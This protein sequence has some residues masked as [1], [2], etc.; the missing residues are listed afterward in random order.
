MKHKLKNLLT[1]S[2]KNPE[3]MIVVSMKKVKTKNN[4]SN[5]STS[6]AFKSTNC[7][8]HTNKVKLKM[9]D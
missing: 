2:M 7:K 4:T 3:I 9:Q 1:T 6:S 5:R 8:K